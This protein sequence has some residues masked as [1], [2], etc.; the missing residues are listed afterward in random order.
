MLQGKSTRGVI[1][2]LCFFGKSTKNISPPTLTHIFAEVSY[3]ADFLAFSVDFSSSENTQKGDFAK[4][5]PKIVDFF[6]EIPYIRIIMSKK[7]TE[8][9]R[10]M[11]DLTREDIISRQP[12]KACHKHLWKEVKAQAQLVFVIRTYQC[13]ACGK[14]KRVKDFFGA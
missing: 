4:S 1:Q 9:R 3:F 13:E 2:K 8:R 5:P 10:E 6:V 7:E 12:G 11:S 14:T